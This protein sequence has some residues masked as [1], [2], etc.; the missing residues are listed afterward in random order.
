MSK[1][2]VINYLFLNNVYVVITTIFIILFL[3]LNF[4]LFIN[5]EIELSKSLNTDCENPIAIYFDKGNRD[6]C[7]TEKITKKNET[8]TSEK[9]LQFKT[10]NL[11]TYIATL[12][13][14]IT[15]AK[16]Y[17]NYVINKES[18]EIN[19]LTGK[20]PEIN[21]LNDYVNNMFQNTSSEITRLNE[22]F[23]NT[24]NTNIQLAIDV[25][26]NLVDSLIR[27]TYT[28]RVKDK[29]KKMVKGYDRI[30]SYLNSASIKPYL[31]RIKDDSDNPAKIQKIKTDLP[32][33]TKNGPG[34]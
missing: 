29:R 11:N 17:Y 34:K 4:Y 30:K 8:L 26:N 5:F 2:I 6:R 19:V 33:K 20:I 31:D 3:I 10:N 32:K 15:D 16:N 22:K 24:I 25:G 27:M 12:N 14:K 13:Q 21:K 18:P 1:N 7:L 9:T 23:E 28:K